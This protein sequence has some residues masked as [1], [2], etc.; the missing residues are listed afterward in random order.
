MA[1]NGTNPAAI[2]G[3]L[4]ALGDP[5]VC[6]LI[7]PLRASLNA[8]WA[9]TITK[10]FSGFTAKCAVEF[11]LDWL[12]E[13]VDRLDNEGQSIFANV[14]A[15]LFRLADARSIPFIADGLRPFP[16]PQGKNSEWPDLRQIDPQEFAA[17]IA[18]K[19]FDLER[20]EE[21]PK[22]MPHVIRAF[23]LT[24]KTSSKDIA[25]LQ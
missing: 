2:I 4:L 7:V 9:T 14:A 19:L 8:D 17:S 25:V 18:Q 22:V 6:Q 23:G 21:S 12:N 24:P 16:F 5:R 1:E 10:C 3:G 13:L 20:R 11:Y 15:G